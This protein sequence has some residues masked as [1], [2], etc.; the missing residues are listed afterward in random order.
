[1]DAPPT[2]P[3]PLPGRVLLEQH[4]R[5]LVFLHWRVEPERVAPYLPPGTR[6]DVIDGA[7]WV[8]LIPFVLADT[9][10]PPLPALHRLGTFVE[11]NVR[12]YA[13]DELGRRGVV[14]RTLEA[15]RLLPV[16]AARVGF[17]LPYHWARARVARR[18]GAAGLELDFRSRRHGVRGP[19]THVRA[20]LGAPLDASAPD[21]ELAAFLT[22]RWGYHERHLGRTMWARN[23]HAQWPL[24]R[25]E[26]LLLEDQ[27]LAASGFPELAS[28]PPDSVLASSGVRT[29]FSR[30][31]PIEARGWSF[32]PIR[33]RPPVRA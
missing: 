13:R 7:T 9:R 14:F 12:L 28:R 8:G 27:L 21:A 33:L 19:S 3:P 10:F 31:R 1:M 22:A 25:A 20:R 2:S 15:G 26:L 4:W 29:A 11:V 17:G 24:V 32:Q 5:D 16:V 6:P 30:P 18:V 23:T